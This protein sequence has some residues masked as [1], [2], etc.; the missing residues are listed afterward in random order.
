MFH[1]LEPSWLWWTP[2]LGLPFLLHLLRPRPRTVRTATL[3]F[4]R[5][6]NRSHNESPW[7]QRLKRLLALLLS[8]ML[9]L[10]ALGALLRPV[11]A[12]PEDGLASVVL[13]IDRSASTGARLEGGERTRLAAALTLARNRLASLPA[14]TAVAVI[15][16]DGRSEILL[17]PTS[18]RRQLATALER[19]A[20]RPVAGTPEAARAALTSALRVAAIATPA[21]V[22]AVGDHAPP[23]L[24]VAPGVRVETVLAA[25]TAPNAGIT[26]CDLRRLP[27]EAGRYEVFIE[28]Q[29]SCVKT[30]AATLR[31]AI[32]GRA[33]GVHSLDFLA[34][35]GR[36]RL[37]LTVDGGA[38][39]VLSVRVEASGDALVADDRCDLLLPPLPHLAVTI[40]GEPDAFTSLALA[41]AARG[42]WLNLGT[43]PSGNW[44]D[45]APGDVLVFAGWTPPKLPAGRPCLLI[46]P[47]RPCPPLRWER[48]AEPF[49]AGQPRVT[50]AGHPLLY[51]VASGRVAAT[52]TLNLSAESGLRPLW[53]SP[54]GTLLAAGEVDGSRVAVLGFAPAAS[55]RLGLTAAHPLLL[56]NTLLWLAQPR[57]DEVAGR[58]LASG[59]VLDLRGAPAWDGEATYGDAS[60]RPVELDRI[61]CWKTPGGE[62]GSSALLSAGETRLPSAPATGP[63]AAGGRGGGEWWWALLALGI[64]V[65]VV[66]PWLAHRLG[67]H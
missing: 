36:E 60:V 2:L 56:A 13:L 14:T 7:L 48:L 45:A 59:T 58:R 4:Y 24:P 61:G 53:T 19:I 5:A 9:L 6:L 47:A 12:A 18:D 55:E 57:L 51:G 67:V 40:V 43:L 31:L 15:V 11:A 26:A 44:T 29:A 41:A 27:L 66:E 54:A 10:A 22:W 62:R 52:Q 21:A 46:D 30:L 39:S 38:G 3:A 49:A 20:A 16:H 64:L 1:L 28:I 50:D 25:D 8:L 42:G 35:G 32:D 33:V 37:T 34:G 63:V 23:N 17:P 65:L